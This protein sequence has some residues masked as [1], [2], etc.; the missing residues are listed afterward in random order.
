MDKKV[1][2]VAPVC[3]EFLGAVNEGDTSKMTFGDKILV[4]WDGK[5]VEAVYIGMFKGNYKF[6]NK[7]GMSIDVPKK[8]L[9]AFFIKKVEESVEDIPEG[10]IM[11]YCNE[12]KK[13]S[14]AFEKNAS[15]MV[16]AVKDGG[17]VDAKDGKDRTA[18]YVAA[19]VGDKEGVDYLIGAK[20]DLN[21]ANYNGRTPLMAAASRGN[22]AIVKALVKAGADVKAKDKKDKTAFDYASPK[23]DPNTLKELETK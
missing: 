7:K 8:N 1:S 13:V 5:Q 11:E 14:F 20:A 2:G 21:K 15:D 18:L 10:V 6:V 3:E 17:D 9:G 22:D 16:K 12:G 19:F 4:D 23:L